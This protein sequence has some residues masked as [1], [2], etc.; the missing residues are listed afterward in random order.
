MD[1]TLFGYDSLKGN[2]LGS[3]FDPGFTLPI[4]SADCSSCHVPSACRVPRGV[5][6]SP[7]VSCVTSFQSEVVETP[8]HLTKLLTLTARLTGGGWG[9]PFSANDDFRQLSADLGHNVLVVSTAACRTHR[10]KL[11]SMGSP[12][13]DPHFIK[14]I[15]RL[16]ASNSDDVFNDFLS[17]YGTHFVSGVTFGASTSFVYKLDAAS[18]KR[19]IPSESDLATACSIMSS[20]NTGHKPQGVKSDESPCRHAVSV[21]V[22]KG[23]PLSGSRESWLAEIGKNPVPLTYDLTSVEALF[24]DVFMG[25]AQT[26]G[27]DAIDY[28]RLRDGIARAKARYSKILIER[29]VESKSDFP[30][31]G[32]TLNLTQLSPLSKSKFNGPAATCAAQCHLVTGCVAVSTCQ[33]CTESDVNYLACYMFHADVST[34]AVQ[35]DNWLTTIVTS[36]LRAP[37]IVFNT[38]STDSSLSAILRSSVTTARACYTLCLAN[39]FCAAFTFSQGGPSGERCTL[40]SDMLQS[41]KRYPGTNMH[42]LPSTARSLLRKGAREGYHLS[43]MPSDWAI[44]SC[45]SNDDCQ[46]FNTE[47]FMGRCVC[48]PEFFFSPA[49]RTCHSGEYPVL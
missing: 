24:S 11:Q 13:F 19:L 33:S 41:L 9:P 21:P 27:D 36:K 22:I 46:E 2:P 43:S 49:D 18:Y 48:K 6:V 16:N 32:L 8:Y 10:A 47:C 17:T 4:F 34:T 15:R 26:L 20:L 14:W 39:D 12:P 29:R 35:D 44:L 45:D 38:M 28:V 30:S 23:V 42:I 40:H 37:F 7:D 31:P 1:D 25:H 5:V 3:G